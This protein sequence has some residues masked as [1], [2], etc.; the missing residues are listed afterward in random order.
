MRDRIRVAVRLALIIVMTAVLVTVR[1]AARP[2]EWVSPR[3]D[4]RIRRAIV[5]LWSILFA[6]IVNM[7]VRVE[8]K[9]PRPPF[10]LVTN[11]LSYIDNFLVGYATGAVFI[12]RADVQQ[13]PGAGFVAKSVNTLFIDR[14]RVRDTARVNR[15]IREEL[16]KGSGVVLYAEAAISPGKDVQPFKSALLEPPAALGLPVHYAALRY[17]TLPG[18]PP[19]SEAVVW[20]GPTPFSEHAR[21]LL[22]LRGFRAEI[23]FGS[24]PIAS[25]D[26]KEL[27]EK[28][29]E[30]VRALFTPLD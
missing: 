28:L 24:E 12:S 19:A 2:L 30:A 16:E 3:L 9:P 26:R 21:R 15:E 17:E 20:F 25:P 8:G 5:R 1:L 22:A 18:E 23:R 7:R 29:R 10:F 13:W 6:R 11:H 14:A 4:R 27:A